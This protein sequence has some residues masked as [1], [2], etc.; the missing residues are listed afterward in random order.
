[1]SVKA[2]SFTTLRKS[3]FF[4]VMTFL[5]GYNGSDYKVSMLKEVD[6]TSCEELRRASSCRPSY[7]ALV[8]GAA[9][10]ALSQ[11]PH[12]NRLVLGFVRKRIVQLNRID[13]SVAV[14]R[15]RPNEESAAYVATISDVTGKSLAQLTDELTTLTTHDSSKRWRLFHTLVTR[16]PLPLVKLV[17]FLPNLSARIWVRHRGGALLVS[18]PAKYGTDVMIAAWPFSLGISFGY[19]KARPM[20]FEGR[21]EARPSMTVTLNFDRRLMAGAPAARFFNTL[22]S[23]LENPNVMLADDSK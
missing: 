19:V 1:M 11:H 15:D 5:N 10:R 8:I 6:M 22:C 17:L 12:A 2:M 4:E 9:A 18:S 20:V 7:T 21:V 16:F 13:V 23:Y 3:P 14:E